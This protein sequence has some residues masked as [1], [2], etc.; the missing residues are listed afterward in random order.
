MFM[1]GK[2]RE[3]SPNRLWDA[4]AKVQTSDWLRLIADA[5]RCQVIDAGGIQTGRSTCEP[6]ID[7]W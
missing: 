4:Y 1:D 6:V 2:P 7:R 3:A 5:R